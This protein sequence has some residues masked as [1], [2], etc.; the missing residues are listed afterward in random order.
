MS[1]NSTSPT[2]STTPILIRSGL[3]PLRPM[4]DRSSGVHVSTVLKDM[5]VKLGL[6]Q[7]DDMRGVQHLTSTWAELGNALEDTIIH[8]LQAKYPT[9]Y[10]QPGELCVDG[11]YGTPDLYDVDDDAVEEIK[12][13]WMSSTADVEGDKMWR[14]WFQ[15]KCYCY[16][17][18]TTLGRLHVCHVNGDYRGDGGGPV[19]NVW[20]R[21]F[22]HRELAETWSAVKSR[23]RVMSMSNR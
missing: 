12:L 17:M 13:A 18:Q 20:E 23:A 10:V 2:P 9:R 6:L 21:R 15:L 1:F 19:Y 7:S 14:Y 5:C 3:E 22:T 4:T 8:R 11:I 16:M